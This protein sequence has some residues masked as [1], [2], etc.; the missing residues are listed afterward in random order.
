MTATSLYYYAKCF[1]GNVEERLIID[2]L[3]IAIDLQE[4]IINERSNKTSK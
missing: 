1:E 3:K 2:I 4:S